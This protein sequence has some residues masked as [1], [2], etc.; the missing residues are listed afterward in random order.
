MNVVL[1]GWGIPYCIDDIRRETAVQPEQATRPLTVVLPEAA[2]GREEVR[3]LL[4]FQDSCSTWCFVC[5]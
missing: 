5:W 2:E 4:G 3:S 1:T